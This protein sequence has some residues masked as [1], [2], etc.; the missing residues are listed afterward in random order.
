MP[1]WRVKKEVGFA[2]FIIDTFTAYMDDDNADE[3]SEEMEDG[4]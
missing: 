4:R 1:P 3:M 2:S